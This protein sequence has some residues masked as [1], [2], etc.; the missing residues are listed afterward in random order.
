ML[1]FRHPTSNSTN[2]RSIDK[3]P[4]SSLSQNQALMRGVY[5]K[6]MKDLT[7]GQYPYGAFVTDK[8]MNAAGG[9]MLVPSCSSCPDHPKL[10]MNRELFA[11]M[12]GRFEIRP[13]G[14][15]KDVEGFMGADRVV[16]TFRMFQYLYWTTTTTKWMLHLMPRPGYSTCWFPIGIDRQT[17]GNS[18]VL[19]KR[20]RRLLRYAERPGRAFSRWDGIYW[21]RPE[22]G[23]PKISGFNYKWGDFK[24]LTFRPYIDRMLLSEMDWQQWKSI[25][26]SLQNRP[27][28][29]SCRRCLEKHPPEAQDES[30]EKM[31]DILKQEGTT[32]WAQRPY[33]RLMAK[34]V[35]IIGTN[36]QEIF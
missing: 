27:N 7:S 19:A 26:Q 29:R 13:Q 14:A 24:S 9:I 6:I 2:F 12:L 15:N 3:D 33:Y 1:K 21:F 5:G 22:F 16:K 36:K 4:N 20:K 30:A 25:A 35:D 32:C 31:V 17:T 8:L 11:G 10:G 18:W 34:Y 23:S 28:R